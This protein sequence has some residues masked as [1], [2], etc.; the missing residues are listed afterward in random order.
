MYHGVTPNDIDDL[1]R[2]HTISVE[3]KVDRQPRHVVQDRNAHALWHVNSEEQPWDRREADEHVGEDGVGVVRFS[4]VA[5]QTK[6][7]TTL[8][9]LNVLHFDD[10]INIRSGQGPSSCINPRG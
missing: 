9:F 4:I 8:S 3:L 1:L 10:T 7:K 2:P 6:G 5:T